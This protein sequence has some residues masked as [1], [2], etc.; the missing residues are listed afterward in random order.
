M[1]NKRVE[2]FGSK[3]QFLSVLHTFP[4]HPPLEQCS[5]S[6]LFRLHRPQSLPTLSLG[7]GGKAI[8]EATIDANKI[9]QVLKYQKSFPKSVSTTFVAYWSSNPNNST[10]I[11]T[12]TQLGPITSKSSSQT[13]RSKWLSWPAKLVKLVA[14]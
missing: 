10:E 5:F 14:E 13:V 12:S 8:R 4:T 7:R 9:E 2:T 3:L 11:P 1:G 6:H